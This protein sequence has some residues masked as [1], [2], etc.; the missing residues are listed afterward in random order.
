MLTIKTYIANAGEKGL[1]LFSDEFVSAGKLVWK[2]DLRFDVRILN[3]NLSH[4]H[5]NFLQ[6]YGCL[7]GDEWQVC[8]DNARFINHSNNPN[9][10]TI[11]DTMCYSTRDIQ[12]G[13]E[14]T[15]D[16]LDICDYEKDNGLHFLNKEIK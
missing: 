8:L 10:K 6:H 7:V 14:I 2:E 3:K 12:I 4:D 1:G 13:E 15:I 5:L 9:I 16:Y 11:D